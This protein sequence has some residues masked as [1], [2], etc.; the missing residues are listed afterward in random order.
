MENNFTPEEISSE[1][2]INRRTFLGKL[3][4]AT[5]WLGLAGSLSAS[6]TAKPLFEI[7][8]A[9]F[10]LASSLFS[11]NLQNMDFPAKAKKDFGINAVEYVS[12]FWKDKAEDK[13]YLTELKQRTADLGI[14]NVL[15]MIDNEGD[16]GDTD[17]AKRLKAVENHYKWIEAAKFLGCH[18]IRVNMTGNGTPDELQKAGVEGYGKLVEF[19]AKAGMGVIIEN[20][21]NVSTNPDWLV[22]LLKQVKSPYAG[23]LPDFGNFTE[24]EMPKTMDLEGYKNAK[25]LHEYDKYEGVKKLMPFAKGVSAKTHTFD[26]KGNCTDTDF[27]K[28]MPILKKGLTSNFKGFIG[29]EY[30]GGFMKM[31]GAK[32]NYLDED[33]GIRATKA[34]LEKALV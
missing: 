11:G 14:R 7:S 6:V 22:G 10:S 28:M 25:I 34:L 20:H 17:A 8:L 5:A 13:A 23:C 31:M 26:S 1:N 27:N 19:G 21:I 24:R 18:S 32:E 29:I 9:E 2:G 15:I 4:M 33:A 16:L 3:G 30:E 12:M